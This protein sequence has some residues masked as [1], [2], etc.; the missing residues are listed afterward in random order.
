VVVPVLEA[1]VKRLLKIAADSHM[2]KLR[3]RVQ[4]DFLFAA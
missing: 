4:L 3:D 1:L 2:A